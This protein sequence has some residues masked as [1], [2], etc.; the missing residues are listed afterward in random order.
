MFKVSL[1]LASAKFQPVKKPKAEKSSVELIAEFIE[2]ELHEFSL[3][4]M[5]SVQNTPLGITDGNM[6]P[7]KDFPHLTFI[8]HDDRFVQGGQSV[9][10]K[11]DI[12]PGSICNHPCPLFR[13]PGYMRWMP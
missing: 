5:V 8:F 11:R 9:P 4:I 6:N 7:G 2:I 3:N 10:L 13:P 1:I 12:R